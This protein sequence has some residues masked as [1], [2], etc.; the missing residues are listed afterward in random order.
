MWTF[1]LIFLFAVLRC[2]LMFFFYFY[3]FY[4]IATFLFIYWSF[5][6]FLFMW[7]FLLRLIP[8]IKIKCLK[9]YGDN[10]TFWISYDKIWNYLLSIYNFLNREKSQTKK[11]KTL[12]KYRKRIYF[13]DYKFTLQLSLLLLIFINIYLIEYMKK[14]KFFI[15]IMK[16]FMKKFHLDIYH[17]IQIKIFFL[18]QWY[19]EI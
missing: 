4:Y 9:N 13:I 12:I 7:T 16:I 6:Y 5:Y 14:Y 3:K 8:K 11:C 15:F 1:F 19:D 10:S 17:E 2:F 18:K